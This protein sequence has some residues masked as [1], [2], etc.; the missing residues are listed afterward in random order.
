MGERE[1]IRLFHRFFVYPGVSRSAFEQLSRNRPFTEILTSVLLAVSAGADNHAVMIA[2]LLKS[3]PGDRTF[4]HL[5]TA[6]PNIN[7]PLT[8]IMS[9]RDKGFRAAD[10]EIP[11]AANRAF[12]VEHISRSIQKNHGGCFQLPY[13]I[14]SYRG[15]SP[16]GLRKAPRYFPASGSILRRCSIGTL[17]SNP[18]FGETIWPQHFKPR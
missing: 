2:L 7:S 14:I 5:R 1:G 4:S 18:S 9:D 10:D 16:D 17:G 13:Q 8:A 15:A 6:V 11:F 12:F 3:L